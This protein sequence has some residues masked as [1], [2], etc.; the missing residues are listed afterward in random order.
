MKILDFR[1]P[2]AALSAL[3]KGELLRLEGRRGLRITS[4]RGSLWLTQDGDPN[5]VVLDPGEAHRLEAD[6]PVLIQELDRACVSVDAAEPARP[7]RWARWRDAW[8]LRPAF[9][10]AA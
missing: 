3:R 4:R 2:A 1:P 8:L 6:G 5:D 7:G 9:G 10:G